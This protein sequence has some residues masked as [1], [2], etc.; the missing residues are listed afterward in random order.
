MFVL[1][2][3]PITLQVFCRLTEGCHSS[4]PGAALVLPA[5]LAVGELSTFRILLSFC[6][7]IDGIGY[8]V[9]NK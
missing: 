1:L 7:F 2:A 5:S 6:A 4:G 8:D 9:K 3:F